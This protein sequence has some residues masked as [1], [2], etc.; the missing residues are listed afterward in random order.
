MRASP[1]TL[2]LQKEVK[3]EWTDKCE[4]SFDILKTLLTEAP[5][6]VQPELGKEFIVYSDVSLNGLGCVLMQYGKVVAYPSRQLKP[7]ERNYP[8]D[9]NLRQH[10][11]LE[12]LKDYNL[13]I[14]Y[15]PGKA[16]VVADALSLKSLFALQALN[17]QLSLSNDGL[18]IAEL[19]VGIDRC[20]LFRGRVCIS[21]SSRL[22]QKILNE[23]YNG[24]MCIHPGSNKM[25]SDLKKIYWLPGMKRDISEFPIIIPEWKWERVTM[26]FVTGL[27]LSLKKEMPSWLHRVPISII[28]NRDPR[29]T[30]RFWSK[31][32]E[33]LGT[34]LHFSTAFHPQTTGQSEHMIQIL[35]DMLRCCILEFR[36][37]WEKYL[38]L[39]EFAYKNSYQSSI[40]MAPYKTL[41]GRKC[42]N[43]LYWTE[44]SEKN[45]HGVDL[46]RETK[47]KV[48]IIRDNLKEASDRQKSYANLKRKEIE[49]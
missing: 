48:K 15:H 3:F 5:V 25:Y 47:E 29:F 38:P 34:H 24:N 17:T 39:I 45:I 49:F 2:L 37:N 22:L 23:A 20:L 31:L 30:S 44:L 10:R 4:Q 1:M 27:A 36:G 9:L 33:A 41:Y 35:K 8:K 46:I 7:H 14:D 12:L 16:N 40:R 32:Q 42:R 21:K 26:D 28:S 11:W 6:L 19:K 43:P 13:V 18:I